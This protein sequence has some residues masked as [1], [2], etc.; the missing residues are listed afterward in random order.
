MVV[1]DILS[2]HFSNHSL[3]WSSIGSFRSQSLIDVALTI[4]KMGGKGGHIPGH[5]NSQSP[6]DMP[7]DSFLRQALAQWSIVF[8][9]IVAHGK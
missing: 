2:V 3:D 7:D 8:G 6:E 9:R 1:G 5:L 4:F